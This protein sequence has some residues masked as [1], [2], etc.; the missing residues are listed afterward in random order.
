MVSR[1]MAIVL[2]GTIGI[3]A[4][5][6]TDLSSVGDALRARFY[7]MPA[8]GQNL[9]TLIS[10][11]IS[12]MSV[13]TNAVFS[14]FSLSHADINSRVVSPKPVDNCTDNCTTAALTS[15][16]IDT[17]SFS[18]KMKEVSKPGSRAN[19]VYYDPDG[20]GYVSLKGVVEVCS[21]KEAI[22]LYWNGWNPFYPK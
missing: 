9:T 13:A 15:V 11:A 5:Q 12:T 16:L 22:E 17:N 19:L 2:I 21:K 4:A 20:D 18:R 10:E 1:L 6:S 8:P 7:S 3:S 14:T